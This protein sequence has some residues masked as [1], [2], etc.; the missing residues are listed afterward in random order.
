MEIKD[1]KDLTLDK[2]TKAIESLQNS[3]SSWKA[4]NMNVLIPMAGAGSRFS[5]AGYA[6]P[7]PLIEVNGKPMIQAVVDNLAIDATY[8]FIVQKEHY[9]KYSLEYLLNAIS[10]TKCNIV[11]VDGITEGAAV[12]ALLAKK[13]IDN[14]E[15]L[16][17]ANSDQIVDWNS[18]EF[19]YDLLSKNADGGIATFKST[20]PKW[21]Y[22][23]I[24]EYGIVSEVAEKKPISDNADRKST[25]LNSSH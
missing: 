9:D 15:P 10:P 1:R 16:V 25:R 11:M 4:S 22:A 18:R 19:I 3:K 14:D 17:M 2:I 20:H 7:K 24:N 5:E 23:K 6:F 21:S 13:F 8:T 12:T